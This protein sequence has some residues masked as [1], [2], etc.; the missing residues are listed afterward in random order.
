MTRSWRSGSRW[1]SGSPRQTW[2]AGSR[3]WST[4]SKWRWPSCRYCRAPRWPLGYSR[5]SWYWPAPSVGRWPAWPVKSR[6]PRRSPWPSS[7]QKW[8][9]QRN[10][11]P[12]YSDYYTEPWPGM[13]PFAVVQYPRWFSPDQCSIRFRDSGPP[14]AGSPY[15]CPRPNHWVRRTP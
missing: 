12:Q 10:S 6:W 14:G 5:F 2:R 1:P 4:A 7:R 15:A 3:S 11:P 8:P 13:K 9:Y